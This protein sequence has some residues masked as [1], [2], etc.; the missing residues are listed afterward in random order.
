MQSAPPIGFL[1]RH[2]NA[3]TC[4]SALSLQGRLASPTAAAAI[5]LASLVQRISRGTSTWVPAPIVPVH[6]L[7]T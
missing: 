1:T 6:S 3:L 7:I 2:K 5:V 4:E